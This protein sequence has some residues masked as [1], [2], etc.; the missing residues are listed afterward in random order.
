MP[1]TISCSEELHITNASAA[2][3][4]IVG[5][6]SVSKPNISVSQ[7]DVTTQDDDCIEQTRPGAFTLGEIT[8]TIIEAAGGPAGVL[9]SE[10][11]TAKATR[12]CKIVYG[13]P[14]AQKD[15]TFSA[16]VTEL[17]FGDATGPGENVQLT[18]SL[19]PTTRETFA[20]TA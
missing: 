4:Q 11:M 15:V 17:N 6:V 16:F 20:D 13:D 1:S 7:V 12:A 14:S 8:G 5:L 9:L 3:T 10:M 2:L 18:F 19:K